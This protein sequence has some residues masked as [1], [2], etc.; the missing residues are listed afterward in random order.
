MNKVK[1]S[2]SSNAVRQWAAVKNGWNFEKIN[3]N[4]DDELVDKEMSHIWP[5]YIALYLLLFDNLKNV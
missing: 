3:L 1:I 4:C 5:T 2:K